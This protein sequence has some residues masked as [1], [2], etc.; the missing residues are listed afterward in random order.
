MGEYNPPLVNALLTLSLA[1]WKIH[2]STTGSVIVHYIAQFSTTG[3]PTDCLAPSGS[4]D[5][6]KRGKRRKRKENSPF[7]H[8]SVKESETKYHGIPQ[9]TTRR[10]NAQMIYIRHTYRTS[11]QSSPLHNQPSSKFELFHA[12]L[13]QNDFTSSTFPLT[14]SENQGHSNWNQSVEFCS[15]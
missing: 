15:V 6:E 11:S 7:F 10:A 14:L 9:R 3:D 13:Q 8:V 12:T 2:S 5:A 1:L 4:T